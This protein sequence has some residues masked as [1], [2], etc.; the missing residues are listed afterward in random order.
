MFRRPIATIALLP[1]ASA[2]TYCNTDGTSYSY[3]ES[4]TT[5]TRSITTN[6]CP[7]H[8]N[9]DVNPNLAV[10]E[11]VTYQVPAAPMYNTNQQTDLSA[12]GGATG[13][14]RSGGMIY[15]AFAGSVALTD[16]ASS[17]V[18]LEGDTFDHCG[19]HSS[20]TTSASYHYHV[21]PSCLVQQLGM[22]SFDSAHSAQ[23]AWSPN[24]FPIYG[25]H[26]PNGVAMQ[27]CTVTGGT[28]GTDVYAAV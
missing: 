23:L 12:K 3:S 1:L 15:S 24:G 10:D 17:A 22:A 7:N 18:A 28:F 8:P 21:P 26:G 5:A 6:H 19:G 25:P 11:A 16:Y 2:Q 27:T 20:S 13:I 4:V 14:A 9:Y